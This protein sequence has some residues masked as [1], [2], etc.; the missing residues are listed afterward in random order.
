LD[1]EDEINKRL[2]YVDAILEGL[3][4]EKKKICSNDDDHDD[5][6]DHDDSD[7][8]NDEGV[9]GHLVEILTGPLLVW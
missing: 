2:D 4:N 5:H 3:G 6:D 1:I 9:L 8:S 7:P